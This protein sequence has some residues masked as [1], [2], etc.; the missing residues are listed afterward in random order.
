MFRSLKAGLTSM[1]R[2]G[3]EHKFSTPRILREDL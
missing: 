2:A 3:L 1:G